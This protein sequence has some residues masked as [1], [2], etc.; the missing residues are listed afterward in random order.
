MLWGS[1]C[2]IRFRSGALSEAFLK[3]LLPR[4]QISKCRYTNFYDWRWKRRSNVIAQVR[5]VLFP[6]PPETW[7]RKCSLMQKERF[8]RNSVVSLSYRLL[9]NQVRFTKWAIRRNTDE[10]DPWMLRFLV[11]FQS[12]MCPFYTAFWGRIP[13]PLHRGVLMGS[14][15]EWSV[16]LSPSVY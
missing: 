9:M 15:F 6:L 10:A 8:L 1:P 16:L 7:I 2:E 11:S 12:R 5:K 4:V 14:I 3:L 13:A